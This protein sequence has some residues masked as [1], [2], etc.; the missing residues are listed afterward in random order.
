MT[1]WRARPKI[2]RLL[3]VP[4]GRGCGTPL[5]RIDRVVVA[6]G[7]AFPIDSGEGL[8][9]SPPGV[10]TKGIGDTFFSG[11]VDGLCP[12]TNHVSL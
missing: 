9:D 7:D 8:G 4:R 6:G 10:I 11:V 12:D 5:L 3:V 1:G 2:D